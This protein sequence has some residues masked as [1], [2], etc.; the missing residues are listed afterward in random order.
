MC[1]ISSSLFLCVPLRPFARDLNR[2]LESRAH[3]DGTGILKYMLANHAQDHF[4]ASIRLEYI[5]SN[6]WGPTLISARNGLSNAANR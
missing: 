3:S 2:P 5:I 1:R 4:P 6:G